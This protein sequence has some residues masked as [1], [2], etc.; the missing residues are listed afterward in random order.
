MMLFKPTYDM[1][2]ISDKI[3]LAI[4]SRTVDKLVQVTIDEVANEKQDTDRKQ[5]LLVQTE[6]GTT[7]E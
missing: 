7:N 2:A 4:E 3:K 6:G 1:N 5:I